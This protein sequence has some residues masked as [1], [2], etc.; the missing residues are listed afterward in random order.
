MYVSVI[1]DPYIILHYVFFIG[2][3]SWDLDGMSVLW[4]HETTADCCW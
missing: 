3:A 1:T 2:I 4:H